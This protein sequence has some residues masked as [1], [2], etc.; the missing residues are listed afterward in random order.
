M[1]LTILQK[2]QN[3]IS[4]YFNVWRLFLNNWPTHSRSFFSGSITFNNLIFEVVFINYRCLILNNAKKLVGFKSENLGSH[5]CGPSCWIHLF[6][7]F[8]S[9]YVRI[10]MIKWQGCA[11]VTFLI[12]VLGYLRFWNPSPHLVLVKESSP[13]V[14][15]SILI[16]PI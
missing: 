14:T 8:V 2:L 11:V 5:G 4:S 12:V 13:S 1:T 7:K 10:N 6:G 9:K 15:I 3:V 16:H